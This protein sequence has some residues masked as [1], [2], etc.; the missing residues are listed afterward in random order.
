M[1]IYIYV[2]THVHICD[3]RLVNE[4]TLQ[5][6]HHMLKH[7]KLKMLLILLWSISVLPL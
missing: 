4:F 3:S 6:A 2:Y 5:E 7:H 1:R